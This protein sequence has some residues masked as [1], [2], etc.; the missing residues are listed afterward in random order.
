[1]LSYLVAPNRAAALALV[2]CAAVVAGCAKPE[3]RAPGTETATGAATPAPVTP[4]PAAPTTSPTISLADVAGKWKMRSMDPSGGNVLEYEMTIPADSSNWGVVG[5]SGRRITVRVVAVGG[6]SIVAEA[7]PYESFIR[8]GV[9]VTQREVYRL[10]DGKLVSTLEAR[11]TTPKGDSV[12]QR[13]TEG[14]RAP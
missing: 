13:R 12:A 3:E 5:P 10:R 6:D 7:G 14:T 8:K 2:C 11:Y 9:M 1:M 4:A